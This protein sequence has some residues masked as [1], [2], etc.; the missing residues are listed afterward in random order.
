M[1]T[2]DFYC[3]LPFFCNWCIFSILCVRFFCFFRVPEPEHKAFAV[4][5][6][7]YNLFV[8]PNPTLT[9]SASIHTHL[10]P[11]CRVPCHCSFDVFFHFCI[12]SMI[13]FEFLAFSPSL[14]RN[15]CLN[16]FN[17][18]YS[19][20]PNLALFLRGSTFLLFLVFVG[21]P[22]ID[23]LMYFSNFLCPIFICFSCSWTRTQSCCSCIAWVQPICEPLCNPNL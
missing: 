23:I 13:F 7:E 14:N 8:S 11:Y 10:S 15:S 12:S 20:P 18:S 17:A 6:L 21:Y 2:L 3:L 22:D 1:T 19:L 5:S 16:R 4:I 9:S